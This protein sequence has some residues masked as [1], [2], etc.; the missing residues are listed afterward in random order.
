VAGRSRPVESVETVAINTKEEEVAESKPVEVEGP[1]VFPPMTMESPSP[2][3]GLSYSEIALLDQDG[4][5]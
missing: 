5:L 1:R 2:S 3:A 4:E